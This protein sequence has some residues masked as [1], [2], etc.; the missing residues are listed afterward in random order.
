M[1]KIQFTALLLICAAQLTIGQQVPLSQAVQKR[2]NTLIQN[3][4]SSVFTAYRAMDWLELKNSIGS[5]KTELSDSIFGLNPN[6]VAKRL[7]NDNFVKAVSPDHIFVIDPFIVAA[8][9]KSNEKNGILLQ[10]TLGVRI[11]GVVKDK[12]SYGA[13]FYSSLTEFPLYIQQFVEQN[14]VAPGQNKV[15]AHDKNRYS[16]TNA[17]FYVNYLP[18]KHFLI[19]AGYGK[20]FIGD[21]YRSLLLSDNA[22][23][24]PYLRFQANFWKF[25][26]NVLYNRYVNTRRIIDGK[27]QGKYSVTHLLGVNIGKKLQLGLFDNIV[28]LARDSGYQKGFDPNYLSP[29][30]FL[31]PVEFATGSSDNAMIGL[32]GKYKIKNGYLYAQAGLDDISLGKS[33]KEGKQS[34]QNKYTLQLGIWNNN[35]FHVNGLSHR[36]EWNSVRPYT[37]GHGFDKPQLNYTHYNQNLANPF[38]ANFNEVISIFQFEKNRWY[39]YFE[40]LYA[41]RGEKPDGQAYNNG[42]DLWGGEENVPEFGSKTMQGVKNKFFYSQVSVGYLINPKNRLSIKADVAYRSRTATGLKQNELIFNFGIRTDLFNTYND[43]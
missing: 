17:D 39:G 14:G 42:E 2:I 38:G 6:A 35:I 34:F 27:Y 40:N 8:G 16:Y 32:T 4:D 26:Y 12:L 24:S 28:W 1:K 19:G 10:G 5:Y 37:Y 29:V 31:R 30:I 18:S 41:V 21:G 13:S 20:Q 25:T 33:L 7:L 22:F 11:Q 36:F 15:Y 9:G 43:F 3:A 23:N